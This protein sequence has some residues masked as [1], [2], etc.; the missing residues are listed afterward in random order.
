MIAVR[1]VA[2]QILCDVVRR[3]QQGHEID[4]AFFAMDVAECQWRAQSRTSW[5]RSIA[6]DR[7]P[8]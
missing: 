2:K 6:R 8:F 4:V 3:A 7:P 5:V 1:R